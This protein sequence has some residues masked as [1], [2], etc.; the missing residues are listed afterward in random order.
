MRHTTFR[1]YGIGAPSAQAALKSGAESSN[2]PDSPVGW[3][4]TS[5]PSISTNFFNDGTP[6]I[7]LDDARGL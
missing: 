1:D 7:N 2:R 6:R 3:N 4:G 5:V